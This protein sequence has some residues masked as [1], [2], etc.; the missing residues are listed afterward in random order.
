[1]GGANEGIGTMMEVDS[2]ITKVATKSTQVAPNIIKATKETM[3]PSKLSTII[4]IYM[5]LPKTF[6]MEMK[7]ELFLW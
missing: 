2:I 3:H 4:E 7:L 5:M 6:N 1:M